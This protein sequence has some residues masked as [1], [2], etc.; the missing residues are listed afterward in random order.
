MVFAS[1]HYQVIVLFGRQ[2]HKKLKP[3]LSL[4]LPGSF[5]LRFAA[6]KLPGSLFLQLPPRFTRCEPHRR[7]P[8]CYN[9]PSMRR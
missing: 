6:R 7:R 2:G 3:W 5:L 4:R 9:I 8:G 1:N